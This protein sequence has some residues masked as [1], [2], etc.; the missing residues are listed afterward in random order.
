ME[1]VILFDLD[2]TLIDST[3][4]IVG[5][6]HHAFETQNYIFDR[7]DEDIKKQIGYPLDIMFANLGVSKESVWD[8]VH[9]YKKR[10]RVISKE[11]TSLLPKAV[12]AV[13]LAAQHARLGIVTT[14]T[15]LYSKELMEHLNL[16]HYFECLIGRE[17]VQNPKPHPEPIHTALNK[18]DIAIENTHIWMIGDTKLDLIAAQKAGIKSVGVTCGYGYREELKQHT[19]NI[20]SNAY[21][22]VQRIIKC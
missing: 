17:D 4:A 10:Y 19:Q 18:M 13:Q 22:A 11:Q 20:D 9:S 3:Q 14:K 5:T 6:M 1:K 21:E 7:S 16:M 2:G 8:F 15:G 12:E